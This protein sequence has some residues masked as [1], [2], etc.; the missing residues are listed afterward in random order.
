MPKPPIDIFWRERVERLVADEGLSPPAIARRLE[1]EGAALERTDYPAERSIR[2]IVADF[3]TKSTYEQHQAESFAW[4][5]SMLAGALPWEAARDALDLLR[6]R[7]EGEVKRPAP[8]VRVAKWFWRLRMAAPTMPKDRA[9][10]Y[11]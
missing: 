2:R 1:Q 6:S 8:T 5:E 4:P 10:W 9:D 3:R 7:Q 11:A